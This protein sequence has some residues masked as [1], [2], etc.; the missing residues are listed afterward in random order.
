LAFIGR[1]HNP[2]LDPHWPL[3]VRLQAERRP[4]SADRGVGK[5]SFRRHRADR[6][7]RRVGRRRLQRSLDNGGNL[8]IADGARAARAGLV[9]QTITSILQK[10]AAPLAYS[11]TARSRGSAQIA[12]GQHDDDESLSKYARSC[13]L[14]TSGAIGR[15]LTPAF[16]TRALLCRDSSYHIM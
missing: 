14:S 9:K 16:A 4:H 11:H 10:S 7:V 5:A 15:P 12:T 3:L 2:T 1:D 6:P 13:G 8:I